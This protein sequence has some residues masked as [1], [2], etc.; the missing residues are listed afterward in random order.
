MTALSAES[1]LCNLGSDYI[2]D[3]LRNYK[4]GW[5][6]EYPALLGWICHLFLHLVQGI[7]VLRG[8]S[9]G[10][11]SGCAPP[12]MPWYVA[13]Y[14][15]FM[16]TTVIITQKDRLKATFT[17]ED[18]QSIQTQYKLFERNFT[19]MKVFRALWKLLNNIK[20]LMKHG[21]GC[22]NNILCS[23]LFVVD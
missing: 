23:L 6:L 7:Y 20:V 1:F 4:V 8:S 5:E 14:D 15:K 19:L 17:E 2:L 21:P 3:V 16:F 12:A 9:N 18:I 11:I 13:E 10:D 22:K